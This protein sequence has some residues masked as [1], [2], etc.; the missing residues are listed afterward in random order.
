MLFQYIYHQHQG[1]CDVKVEVNGG[2][3]HLHFAICA[4]L[5]RL[6]V[7]TRTLMSSFLTIPGRT[8]TFQ[9]IAVQL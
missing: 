4:L 3:S 5:G 9:K 6:L 1:N 7:E 2:I 8:E